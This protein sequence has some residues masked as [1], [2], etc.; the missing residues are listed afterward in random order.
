MGLDDASVVDAIGVERESGA[1]ILT[2][3]DS[4]SWEDSDHHLRALESKLNAYFS[5]I[6]SGDIFETYPDARGRRIA[7]DLV[8]RWE[9]PKEAAMLIDKAS[10]LAREIGVSI[11]MKHVPE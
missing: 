5:F 1:V 8:V 7:I 11:R 2:I 10:S 3:V 9:L 6:E 4:W